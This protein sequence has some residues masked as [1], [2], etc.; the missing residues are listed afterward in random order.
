MT[1]IHIECKETSSKTTVHIASQKNIEM[2]AVIESLPHQYVVQGHH[3]KSNVYKQPVGMKMIEQGAL[4]RLD[5]VLFLP[6]IAFET[7]M[8]LAQD[9]C[10][11]DISCAILRTHLGDFHAWSLNM[12]QKCPS[13]YVADWLH[14]PETER[15]D[16]MLG[17]IIADKLYWS[18]VS[19]PMTFH[20]FARDWYML[21]GEHSRQDILAN[22][23][24]TVWTEF[25]HTRQMMP[26]LDTKIVQYNSV[27]FIDIQHNLLQQPMDLNKAMRHLSNR[28][29]FDTV[30]VADARGFLLAGE[31]MKEQIRVVMARKLGKLPTNVHKASYSKEYGEDEICI[32][33]DAIPPN[34]HVIIVDDILATGGTMYAIKEL[35]E[36]KFNST[37]VA[38]IAPFA[39]ETTPGTLLCNKI[40]LNKIRFAQTQNKLPIWEYKKPV[41][42]DDDNIVIIPPSLHTFSPPTYRANVHWNKFHSS[43]NIMFD[44]NEFQDKHIKM[45]INV[46]NEMEL[47]ESLSLLK[48]LYRKDPKSISVV[49]PFTEQGTQDRIEYDNDGMETLAQ[50]D[51]LAKMFGKQKVTTF[52]LHAEQSIFA[53][54]DLRN[55]SIVKELWNMYHNLHP[56]TIP[57]FPDDG[58]AKRFGK[59]LNVSKKCITFRK[60][61]GEGDIRNVETEDETKAQQDYVIIDD[62]VRTASTMNSV[63]Q[64]L[65][66]KR[67]AKSVAILFAHAPFEPRA[68]KHLQIFGNNIWTSNSCPSKVP[69]QWVKYTF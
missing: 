56:N 17:V 28:L 54:H 19:S 30:I 34:S 12:L 8:V 27:P 50:S 36:E 43:S 32:E 15:Q 62:L 39:I 11:Y 9:G 64:Y 49:V 21:F 51:T 53:F 47:Y 6:C 13:E 7:G 57:V 59:L 55:L 40:P 58:A 26:I 24:T 2:N 38:F 16:I 68:A 10:Y 66:N 61:R 46:T 20:D 35:V 63:A 3:S 65:L 5:S 14:L 31:F 67:D 69:S 41:F 37:V 29:L 22:I 4:N 42:D 44:G 1:T 52:D 18:A 45:F 60:T 25:V 33:V 23:F 48:I